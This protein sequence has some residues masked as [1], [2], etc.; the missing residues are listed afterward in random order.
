M[1]IFQR[2]DPKYSIRRCIVFV[3]IF[4]PQ[5]EKTPICRAIFEEAGRL[6]KPIVPVLAIKDWRSEDWLGLTIARCSLSAG[7]DMKAPSPI[8]DEY[9]LPK[10]KELDCMITYQWDSQRLVRKFYEDMSMREISTWFDIWCSMQ[11][12]TNKAMATGVECAKVLLVFL[13][14]AY[15]KSANCKMEFRYGV[16]RGKAFFVIRTEP[17]IQME[18][19]IEKVAIKF[20]SMF[21]CLEIC[22]GS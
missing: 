19:W 20:L 22:H 10:R 4:S 3:P 1:T 16:K 6:L 13:S 2:T 14:K 11:V 12:N 15:I 5:L 17:N 18:Q 7:M 9:G 8:L 21:I